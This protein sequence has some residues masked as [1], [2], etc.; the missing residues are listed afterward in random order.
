[1]S[2]RR[3]MQ[4]T[5]APAPHGST[6]SSSPVRATT[7]FSREVGSSTWSRSSRSQPAAYESE[8]RYNALS[9]NY[10]NYSST[11]L[12]PVFPCDF[13]VRDFSW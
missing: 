5:L 4:Y 9:K 8:T 13:S 6:R 7:T 10:L 2:A 1:M 3:E 11:S 12:R